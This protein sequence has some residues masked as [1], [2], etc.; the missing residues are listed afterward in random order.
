MTKRG[1]GTDFSGIENDGLVDRYVLM[2]KSGF[3]PFF[4]QGFEQ[5]KS[6]QQVLTENADE[7]IQYG[8]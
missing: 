2:K 8:Q 6:Q 7:Q 1:F 4:L 5:V 3:M